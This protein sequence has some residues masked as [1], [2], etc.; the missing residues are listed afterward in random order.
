MAKEKESLRGKNRERTVHLKVNW[1][2]ERRGFGIVL[3]IVFV[4]SIWS[5]VGLADGSPVGI[6]GR[7]LVTGKR[8]WKTILMKDQSMSEVVVQKKNFRHI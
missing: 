5:K 2:A 6:Q 1:M 4:D 7:S 3:T 8:V